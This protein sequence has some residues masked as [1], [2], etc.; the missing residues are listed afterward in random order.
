MPSLK[1]ALR[2]RI[3]GYRKSEAIRIVTK[4]PWT[5]DFKHLLPIPRHWMKSANGSRGIRAIP[6]KD[7]IKYWNIVPGDKIR[8]RGDRSGIIQEVMAINK[9]R[10]RVHLKDTAT[11]CTVSAYSRSAL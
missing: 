7:R 2:Q 11:V 10:N 6:P 8:V 1:I 3:G 9:L 5:K 4:D